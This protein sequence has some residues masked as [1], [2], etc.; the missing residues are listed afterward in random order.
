MHIIC[1]SHARRIVVFEKLNGAKV[2][3]H[4]EDGTNCAGNVTIR[5]HLA[6]LSLTPS[7][8]LLRKVFGSEEKT[9]SVETKKPKSK[10]TRARKPK[11]PNA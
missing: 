9:T 4:R 11:K 7:E 6:S 10:R 8:V 5:Q 1:T 3:Q 2:T